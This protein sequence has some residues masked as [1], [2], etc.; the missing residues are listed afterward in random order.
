VS[1]PTHCP[2]CHADLKGEPIPEKDRHHFGVTHFS[3]V[4]GLY[5]RSRDRTTHWRCPDCGREWERE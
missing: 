3:R 2:H 4:I 5:D 1:E